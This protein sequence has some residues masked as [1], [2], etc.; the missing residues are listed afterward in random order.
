MNRDSVEVFPLLGLRGDNGAR[1][2]A[3]ETR[4][5]SVPPPIRP[6]RDKTVVTLVKKHVLSC[7]RVYPPQATPS[8]IFHIRDHHSEHDNLVRVAGNEEL[9]SYY[10]KF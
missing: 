1:D 2:D 3:R 6:E 4:K 8:N 10:Q 5:V 7:F 9:I